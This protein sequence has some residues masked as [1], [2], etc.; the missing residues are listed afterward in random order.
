MHT[1]AHMW[2]HCGYF[3]SHKGIVHCTCTCTC[4]RFTCARYEVLLHATSA[5]S[6]VT[7]KVALVALKSEEDE[8]DYKLP[9]CG[10][11]KT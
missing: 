2:I 11:V 1:Y 4:K 3:I 6:I 10:T 7:I 9:R 5:V 8:H